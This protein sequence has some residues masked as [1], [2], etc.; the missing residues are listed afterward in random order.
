MVEEQFNQQLAHVQENL[1]FYVDLGTRVLSAA[2]LMMAGW[3]LGNWSSRRIQEFKRIDETLG[4][5]L[6]G[7][8]K[9]AV[10][11]VA[12][13][14]VLGQFGVETASLLAVLGGAALA[15]GLALQGT[16][17]NVAAGTMMLIL[18]PFKVG[19][20]ITFA[21]TGG[22]VKTL[23]LFGTELATPD[24]V[25]IFAP[26]SQIWG[27]DIFNYSR[28]LHR[29]QDI[30]V[31]ISYDDDI[32][33]A[34]KVVQKVLE[35]EE[36]V[37]KDPEDKQPAVLTSQ[38]GDF[39]INL[40]ARFWSLSTDYWNLR[41]ALTKQIKEALDKEGITI[42]FPTQIEIQRQGEPVK[43]KSGSP[44]PKKKIA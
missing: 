13:I 5:F 32:G 30:L 25:Y 8:A 2:L 3:I 14:T 22:T 23:G 40:I 39:S 26:N 16:L 42:P 18:R 7:L 36:R 20:Y 10:L 43:S 24:N 37:L 31:S 4:S 21:G 1:P 29:R 11:A 38:M 6:G 17:S 41:W 9:Y 15:I 34:L 33:K 27:N 28:N 44:K 12:L 19:D 35:T